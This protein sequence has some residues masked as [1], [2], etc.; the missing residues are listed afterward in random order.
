MKAQISK[1]CHQ[2][3]YKYLTMH[4]Y[5]S[6]DIRDNRKGERRYSVEHFSFNF[7]TR[8]APLQTCSYL[9]QMHDLKK[10]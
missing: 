10:I 4:F 7:L 2:Y 3:I 1:L 9:Y 6:P 5:L 8:G